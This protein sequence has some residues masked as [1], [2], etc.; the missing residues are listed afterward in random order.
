MK[1]PFLSIVSSM[2]M[3]SSMYHHPLIALMISALLI[4]LL[5]PSTPASAA[6]LKSCAF[7]MPE[8]SCASGGLD[9]TAGIIPPGRR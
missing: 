2:A 8:R 7:V 5:T 9:S 3:F 1:K 4:R 6:W